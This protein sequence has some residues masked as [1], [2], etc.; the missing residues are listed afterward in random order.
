MAGAAREGERLITLLVAPGELAT[1]ELWIEGDRYRHLFRARR[2]TV[3]EPLRLVDG[4]GRARRAAIER[5]ERG[6][7]LLRLS[8][9]E[10]VP[11]PI[12]PVELL[13]APP[14]PPRAT[15]LVE[16]AT[17]LGVVAIRFIGGE[18]APRDYGDATLERL[19]RVAAAALEQSRQSRLPELSGV[20]PWDELE[21]LLAGC[22]DRRRFERGGE[23]WRPAAGGGRLALVV[24][25]EGG[26][27]DAELAA[28]DELGCRAT[29]LGPTVLRV[30]TAAIVG[31]ALA[32]AAP[33][34]GV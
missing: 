34:Q 25:P 26:W 32:L 27:S 10:T 28:L 8:A 29:A 7:A 30:E 21:V 2:L 1:D 15:W 33:P 4:G 9:A 14:R 13:V 17:E 18:R 11:G 6:R 12:R 31:A 23:P 19:R 20:H 3:G 24:G 16:K 5:L 22:A